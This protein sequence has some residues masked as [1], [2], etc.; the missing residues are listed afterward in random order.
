LTF[1]AFLSGI[2]DFLLRLA[3]LYRE[4]KLRVTVVILRDENGQPLASPEDVLP[5][6]QMAIDLHYKLAKIRL[7]PSYH[8]GPLPLTPEGLPKATTAWVQVAPGPS[9]ACNLDVHCNL[10]AMLEDI[11]LAGSRFEWHA[12]QRDFLGNLRRILGYGAPI[13]I[14]VVRSIRERNKVFGGCSI[15]PLSDYVT[16]RSDRHG[17]RTI[18]H[19]LGHALNLPHIG[20]R[21]N[22]MHPTTVNENVVVQP[23]Q[24]ALLRASRH[25]SYF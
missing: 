10:P 23:W 11:W 14:F 9:P 19:E 12:T 2:F 17:L 25:A 18:A 22:L 16:V 3:G 1:L 4:K 20:E 7:L 6:L 13:V 5:G 24:V 21:D 8:E 15:G